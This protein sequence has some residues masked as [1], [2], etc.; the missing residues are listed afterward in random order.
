MLQP[1]HNNNGPSSTL[2]TA[3]A[4]AAGTTLDQ[5]TWSA[6]S[7][8]STRAQQQKQFACQQQQQP[9]NMH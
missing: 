3:A 4:A 5:L 7:C 1:L 6:F 8:V 9:R 2:L